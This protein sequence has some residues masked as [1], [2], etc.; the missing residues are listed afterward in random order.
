MSQSWAQLKSAMSEIPGVLP[1]GSH[2]KS[3][4]E[5]LNEVNGKSDTTP[6]VIENSAISKALQYGKVKQLYEDM[7]GENT[8][9][10]DLKAEVIQET[11]KSPE[12]NP[13]NIKKI[14]SALKVI[15]SLFD[16]DIT[17]DNALKILSNIE[18]I[19]SKCR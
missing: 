15:Q 1:P 8:P 19:T 11:T 14:I 6:K 5:L 9:H 13:I 10:V 2:E 16:D 18:T 3:M 17:T 7:I 12:S 4:L